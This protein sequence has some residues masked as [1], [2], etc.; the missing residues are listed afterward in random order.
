MYK[1]GRN[2]QSVGECLKN[3]MLSK[4]FKTYRALLLVTSWGIW[5][6]RKSGIF[7]DKEVPS[8]QCASQISH[9]FPV[10]KYL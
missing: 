2:S 3:W 10:S 8:S 6:A 5:I 4:E 7:Q 9:I 1:G